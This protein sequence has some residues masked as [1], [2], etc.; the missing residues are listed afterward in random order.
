MRA[1]VHLLSGP[2]SSGKTRRLVE[3]YRTVSRQSVGSALWLAPTYRSVEALRPDLLADGGGRVA[4]HV[5]TFQ[6]FVEALIRVNDPHARRLPNLQRRLL[7]DDLVVRLH[8]EGRLSHFHRIVDT[9]GFAEDV[10]AF[11]AVLKQNEIWPEAF[12]A[13]VERPASGSG[14]PASSKDQQCALL[15]TLY[16]NQ[17]IR[18][19][20]YDH[21]G[22]FWYARDL[23]SKGRRQPF[24]AVRAVFVDGFTDFTRTQRDIL[25][26][27]STWVSE[28]WITLPGEAGEERA[29]LF[30]RPRATRERL[31]SLGARVE[32]LA[33]TGPPLPAGLRH[34]A[35]QL[36]RPL[37]AIQPAGDADGLVILE[38]PG[39]LGEARLVAREIKTLLLSGVTAEEIL[40]IVRDVPPS[41][42]LLREVFAEYGIPLD[43]EGTEPV[44]RNPAVAT[45]LRAFRLPEEDWPF[46]GVT[47]LLRS[48]YFRP[49]WPE[50]RACPELPG[51]AEILLRLLGEP[52][53]REPYLRAVTKW[54]EC[55]DPGLED[56][57]AEESRRL[58]THELAKLCRPFLQRFFRTW[59]DTPASAPL[60][61]HLAWLQGF[62]DLL[63]VPSVAAED[64]RDRAALHRF[65]DELERWVRLEREFQDGD[66]PRERGAFLR[67]LY[68]LAA[69]AGLART[70]RGPG[71]VRVLSAPMARN[72][73]A[74]YV[75]VLGLGECGFPRLGAP[76]PFFDENKR[77]AFKLAG[78]DFPCVSEVL[79]DEM[80]L[81][82]Q[83]VTRAGRRLVLSYP[84]VDEKGQPLLPSPFLSAVRDCFLPNAVETRR[85]RMLTEGYD[86]D[87]PLSPAEYRVQAASRSQFAVGSGQT[88]TGLVGMGVHAQDVTPSSLPTA[89]CPLPTLRHVAWQRFHNAEFGPYDGWLQHP[90]V[91]AELREQFGPEQVFSPTALEDYV[92]CPFRFFLKHVLG[93]QPLEEPREEIEGTKR[94]A[95]FHR[96][97][98]R[99][100][101]HLQEA[102]VHEPAEV[103]DASLQ[104]RL[105][106]AVQEYAERAGS[107][108]SKVLWLLEGQRL[109]RQALRY[110]PHW[111]KFVEP[112]K[113]LAVRP[114]PHFFETGFGMPSTNGEETAAALVIRV[115]GEEVRLRGRIDRVDI[116]ELEDGI[117]FWVIDYKTGRSGHYTGKDLKQFVRL[118]LTLYALAVERV[119]FAGQNAR[120]MGLA[121]WLV[122][123]IGA[124]VVLPA[125]PKQPTSW[126]LQPKQWHAVRAELENWVA[127]LVRHIRQGVFPLKPRFENCTELCDYSQVCRINQAR[128]VAKTWSLELPVLP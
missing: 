80:L 109:K 95:A 127:T 92:A 37:R 116:A 35:R 83:V 10:F 110:R 96:A 99:L 100:H 32:Y 69:E 123:D 16:Q 62:A 7:A 104:Q 119:L 107:P 50:T 125:N 120:P 11:L 121:Y 114:R 29:E 13:A 76:E 61:V 63:G 43:I 59:E 27:L 113:P 115:D 3:R 77:Q 56:E 54:A 66:R 5:Y 68:A 70:P 1:A 86:R 33:D 28:L 57:Q 67:V 73:K 38:A 82:Y 84:A 31:L 124:K 51:Q 53:G 55:P 40:V 42:D 88:I 34:L 102:G 78:L 93:L 44:A 30:A 122:T 41:A 14:R 60:A 79:P 106:E 22:S 2:A 72:L 9:R 15:Y 103:V 24:A 126:H 94:G 4:P 87:P 45:L 52:R 91:L 6:D 18:H 64:E 39:Q 23:L 117:G 12:A 58:R 46:A 85:R 48:V 20:L 8:E 74:P 98:S 97:L 90:A 71:R 111:Q 19:N 49:D 65:W 81:F 47:A 75:F 36:F 17:L 118:Q 89:H 25:Q 105:D 21:E 26:E 112:W 128:A 108:A 101:L